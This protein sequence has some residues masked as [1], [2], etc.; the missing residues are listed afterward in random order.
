MNSM[1]TIPPTSSPPT[2]SPAPPGYVYRARLFEDFGGPEWYWL[3]VGNLLALIPLAAAVLLLWLP[4]QLYAALGAPLA[5]FAAPAWPPPIFWLVGAGIIVGSMLLHE[6]LHGLALIRLGYHPR[7]KWA[8]G[9]FYATIQPGEYL[10]RRHYLIM[11]L[12]PIVSMTLGGTILLL[13]LP[14]PIG[15]GLLIALLLNAAASIGDLFV[16][17]RVRRWPAATLFGD[18]R[19]IKVFVPGSAPAQADA[20]A[21][22]VDQNAKGDLHTEVALDTD[23]QA[24]V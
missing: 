9:Y 10:T 22:V 14:V 21:G 6:A 11:V 3:L 1:S 17:D 2:V 8:S 18:V 20:A 13:L 12:T 19:G 16:A 5:L 23:P 4:Y 7:L 24:R 15:Q